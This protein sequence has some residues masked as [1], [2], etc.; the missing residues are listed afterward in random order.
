MTIL[1]NTK[2]VYEV[3]GLRTNFYK[4]KHVNCIV[5][6]DTLAQVEYVNT[7]KPDSI[8]ILEREP[9]E[10]IKFPGYTKVSIY[11]IFPEWVLK[12]NYNNWQHRTR[13]WNIRKLKKTN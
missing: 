4:S 6:R 5:T 12:N 9:Y 11:S 3:S 8:L 1:S 7:Q 10:N 2:E 13:I